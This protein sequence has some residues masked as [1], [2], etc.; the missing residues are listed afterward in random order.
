VVHQKSHA[1]AEHVAIDLA[2]G[3]CGHL[4]PAIEAT[5]EAYTARISLR[6]PESLKVRP[7]AAAASDGVSVNTWLVHALR[8]VEPIRGVRRPS[9]GGTRRLTGYG[10]S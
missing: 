10:R 3:A 7:E 9:P 5:D 1:V 8:H 2:A 4:H 6:L